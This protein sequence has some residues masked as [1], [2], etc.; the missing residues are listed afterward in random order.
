MPPGSVT[1]LV[2]GNAGDDT[3]TL[4]RRDDEASGGA[5]ADSIALANVSSVVNTVSGGAGND[6]VFFNT[7]S[8]SIGGS[9]NL[10]EGDDQFLNTSVQ[11]VAVSNRGN[12]GADTLQ[13]LAGAV[14]SLVGGGANADL[15]GL[16]AGTIT[17][18]T[19]LGGGGADTLSLNGAT[20]SL[21]TVQSS[22]G[23]DILNASGVNVTNSYIAAGKGLDSIVLGTGVA[24]STVA[25][26][27]GADTIQINTTYGGG[28]IYGD[29]GTSTGSL[30]GAD[31]IGGSA[32]EVGAATSVYGAGGADTIKFVSSGAVVFYVDGGEGA[33]LIGD[34]ASLAFSADTILGG[35]GADTISLGSLASA[36]GSLVLGGAD[37]DVIKVVNNTNIGSINGG[38]GA[39][40][41]VIGNT[42]A[43]GT[44]EAS[45]GSLFTVN[46][47]AGADTIVFNNTADG[48]AQFTAITG[49]IAGITS[50]NGVV[51]YEAGDV[52]QIDNTA[53]SVSAANFGGAG[54][55]IV[56]LSRLLTA[57]GAVASQGEGGVSVFSDG[58]DTAFFIN[59][60]AT[61]VSTSIAYLIKGADLVST[62]SVGSVNN[63][64]G[65]FGFTIAATTGTVDAA[66]A[67]G[68]SFTLL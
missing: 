68:L 22:D 36:G 48:L 66:G 43:S 30:N 2:A 7:A 61:N 51:V 63:S 52:I 53:I 64:T 19:V 9:T 6:S 26:G 27:G 38:A 5:G 54:G 41:I 8:V 33:D 55:Q 44:T 21:S 18:S 35:A 20:F 42:N 16:T 65:N 46:G 29:G 45:A 11:M 12:Q 23:H 32:M 56:V 62:T 25:G 14:N 34:T 67:A 39:D 47:G 28:V 59:T 57:F 13:F 1:A 58:T 40:S 3:I 31:L 4:T 10:N 37:A 17:S 24:T 15:I 60:A 50:Y 49:G